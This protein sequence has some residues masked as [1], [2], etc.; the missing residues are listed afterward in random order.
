MAM[1]PTRLLVLSLAL[2]AGCAGSHNS[3]PTVAFTSPATDLAVVVGQ[4]VTIEYLDDD[5]DD[6]AST[7]IV[8]DADGDPATAFDQISIATLLEADGSPHSVVWET[9]AASPGT[10]ALFARSSDGRHDAVLARAPGAVTI[11]PNPA[12][13]VDVWFPVTSTATD[14]TDLMITGSASDPH[15]VARV[16]VSGVDAESDDGFATWRARVPLAL[17]SNEITIAATDG[18]G[19]TDPAAARVTVEREGPF[20]GAVEGITLDSTGK[21]AYFADDT[22]GAIFA[23]DVAANARRII[24][25]SGVGTGPGLSDPWSVALDA[26]SNRLVVFDRAAL[27]FLTVDLATGDRATLT[28]GKSYSKGAIAI[29]ASGGVGYVADT[30]LYAVDLATGT[31]TLLVPAAGAFAAGCIALDDANQRAFVTD[32]STNILFEVDLV[33][34]N[35]QPLASGFRARQ[36]AFDPQ[37][38]RLYCACLTDAIFVVDVATGTTTNVPL[39]AGGPVMEDAKGMTWHEASGKLLVGFWE[40]VF[41]IDPASGERTRLFLEAPGDMPL[42]APSGIDLSPDGREL[43]VLDAG[44]ERLFAVD[45]STRGTRIVS[46]AN[47]GTGASLREAGALVTDAPRNSAIMLQTTPGFEPRLSQVDLGTGD[48]SPVTGGGL[49]GGPT[50]RYPSSVSVT[51]DGMGAYVADGGNRAVYHVDVA[52]GDRTVVNAGSLRFPGCAVVDPARNRLII[53][54]GFFVAVDLA[55]GQYGSFDTVTA[56]SGQVVVDADRDRMILLRDRLL[57]IDLA[58]G[59]SREV[60]PPPSDPRFIGAFDLAIDPARNRAFILSSWVTGHTILLVDLG[61]GDRVTLYR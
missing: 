59:A 53:S 33:T 31:R 22:R 29:P 18:F 30:N 50:F 38:G 28:S 16:V 56:N 34:G 48:R 43:L 9:G 46:D 35:A 51:P 60:F 6:V 14:R 8:A 26:P 23:L 27:D 4:P 39:A 20:A 3:A 10:Y 24:S 1:S 7:E 36:L 54:D 40:G 45:L 52:T 58:T 42:E 15:G 49:G 37:R 41:A 13:S 55:T 32:W 57:D 21:T 44:A 61:S 12:P 11:E 19:I 47:T 2:F 25:G 5:P 17:G